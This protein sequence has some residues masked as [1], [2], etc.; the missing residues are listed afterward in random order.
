MALTVATNV[1]IRID[2][3]EEETSA[4]VGARA[5]QLRHFMAE[6]SQWANGTSS[7][8][9]NRAYSTTSS[10][11]AGVPVAYD[12]RGIA[13]PLTGASVE[14]EHLTTICIRHNGTTASQ[15]LTIGGGSNPVATI[16][17]AAGDASVLGPG[18]VF[19]WTSPRDGAATA[20]G[21]ADTLT[22]TSSSGT[23]SFDLLILGRQA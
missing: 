7:L 8:Q 6:V 9:Q 12:L 21:T 14:F 16:W 20:A 15:T 3:L 4:A 10:V 19:V 5:S 18:G 22:L 11:T 17:G 2:A 13:D 1:A 23:V